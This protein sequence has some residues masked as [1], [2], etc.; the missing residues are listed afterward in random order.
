[1]DVADGEHA[2]AGFT[3]DQLWPARERAPDIV[4]RRGQ[5]AAARCLISLSERPHRLRAPDA[6][7]IESVLVG[8]ESQRR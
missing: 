6:D 1:M 4:R 3:L 5:L 7:L 2:F 8:D